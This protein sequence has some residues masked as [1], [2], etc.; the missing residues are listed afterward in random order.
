MNKNDCIIRLEKETDHRKV[1]EMTREAFWN[2]YRPGC[3]EHYIVH[4]YRSRADFIP[5][6]DFVLEKDGEI[7]GHIMY[8]RAE[9]VK[10]DGTSVPIVI[11]GP[12]SIAPAY[13]RKGYGGL[14]LEYSLA[15]AKKLGA[16]A[17]ALTGD[18]RFYGR[19]G[20]VIG[21][22]VDICHADDPE[23]DYFLI[24]ELQKGFF[25]TV[26]G[27]YRDPDGY[28][29]SD[30]NVDAFDEGFPYK[31]KRKLPGQLF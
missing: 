7:I 8:V 3:Y 4:R 26:K 30:E 22:E 18:M 12:L 19:F 15:E 5:E 27:T 29:V 24:K 25:G 28:F 10:E 1:E 13:Q 2:F 21:N 17:V 31:E 23:A 14:L 11:F 20:F 6:L 16:P 9:I